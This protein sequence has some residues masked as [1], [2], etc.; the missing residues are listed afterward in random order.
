MRP[1]GQGGPLYSSAP[2]KAIL[3]WWSDE[4]REEWFQGRTLNRFTATTLADRAS[5]ERDLADARRLG[6]AVDRAEGLEG[7][8]CVAAPILDARGGIL[9]A[10][11]IMA[12]V[13]RLPEERFAEAAEACTA[14]ARA[15]EATL[16]A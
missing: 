13:S 12:P 2:G 1:G 4:R 5:L 9:A 8:H 3:A 11:T 6:Y 7:I 14:A 15:I 10:V 16:Q